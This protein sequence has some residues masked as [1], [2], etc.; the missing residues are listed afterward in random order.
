MGGRMARVVMHRQKRGNGMVDLSI[1]V[2]VAVEM[3]SL[4]GTA[5]IATGAGGPNIGG[6]TTG[7]VA[8]APIWN[9]QRLPGK[10]GGT[11]DVLPKKRLSALT[12]N[13]DNTLPYPS[14]STSSSVAINTAPG[15]GAL[16][17]S[18]SRPLPT[19][20]STSLTQI[21]THSHSQAQNQHINTQSKDLY[22][23]N[24]PSSAVMSQEQPFDP[25]QMDPVPP[26]TRDSFSVPL[27]ELLAKK[28]ELKNRLKQY[29]MDFARENGRMPVKA[30]KEP[31]RHLYEQY[32]ALKSQIHQVERGGSSH[33]TTNTLALP[34]VSSGSS[35]GTSSTV[36]T[37]SHHHTRHGSLGA[38][39][40][41]GTDSSDDSVGGMEGPS[42][43][44]STS[45]HSRSR[46]KLRPLLNGGSGASPSASS[47]ASAPDLS[48][49]KAE[50][51]HLHQ[52]LRS[53][54][55]DF[56]RDNKRQVSSFADIRPVA[57]QYRRY[58]EIKKQIAALQ[59]GA[60]G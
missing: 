55:K 47:S 17:S 32:N 21:Q 53:Y 41:S 59:S 6:P 39:V 57:D 42:A 51:G 19:S 52:M 33:N 56:Y 49:L 24:P 31:I 15:P 16:R 23:H 54:E 5:N 14:S 28:R 26:T 50:K 7:G 22:S 35:A 9:N 37:R 34:M 12:T 11:T 18:S 3:N 4:D 27:T 20:T 2:P 8:L 38:S 45:H 46:H 60:G 25:F 58:K 1:P 40:S 13:T 44:E 36:G 43:M 30:E 29:D 48:A 10:R